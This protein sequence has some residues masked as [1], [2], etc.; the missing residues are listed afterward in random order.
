VKRHWLTVATIALVGV[1]AC[2]PA[3]S[4][5]GTWTTGN[6]VVSEFTDGSGYTLTL[7][8]KGPGKRELIYTIDASSVG[9]KLAQRETLDL[10]MDY[11][12][13]EAEP[14]R[15]TAT[16]VSG[17]SAGRVNYRIEGDAAWDFISAISYSNSIVLGISKDASAANS[18]PSIVFKLNTRN[19]QTEI[20]SNAVL[21]ACIE[22]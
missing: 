3:R 15:V 18:K 19:E 10:I 13:R 2:G 22:A 8:C 9:E 21:K 7:L 17:I 11:E 14:R 16:A 20:A 5:E 4:G 1:V 6:W 12:S